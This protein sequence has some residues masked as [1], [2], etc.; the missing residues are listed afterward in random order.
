[1]TTLNEVVGKKLGPED[2]F[3][4]NNQSDM[5]AFF[6]EFRHKFPQNSRVDVWTPNMSVE[7]PKESEWSRTWGGLGVTYLAYDGQ[8]IDINF[9]R[10]KEKNI[11][12]LLTPK[13]S[14]ELRPLISIGQT[15][16][17][18]F[19]AYISIG[20]RSYPYSKR[21]ELLVGTPPNI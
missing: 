19:Y 18:E 6:N 2:F 15:T 8:S 17:N 5:A 4:L 7:N 3:Q 10:M 21:T 11:Q 20:D 9:S 13:L 1:M 12:R 16:P 14:P